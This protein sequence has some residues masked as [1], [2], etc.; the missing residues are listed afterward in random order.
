MAF[1]E[2]GFGNIVSESRL[3]CVVSPDSAP[4]RRIV[5]DA[6]D[7]GSLIDASSG[8]KSKAVLIMDSDHVVLSAMPVEEIRARLGR[9]EREQDTEEGS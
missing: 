2:I 1:I 6:R 8:K 9:S 7:R 4:V 5:Q 3:I